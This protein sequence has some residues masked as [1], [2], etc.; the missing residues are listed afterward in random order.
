MSLYSFS[1]S[2]DSLVAINDTA[3][4]RSSVFPETGFTVIDVLSIFVVNSVGYTIF[5]SDVLVVS[6][7]VFSSFRQ[8]LS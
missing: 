6:V 5:S 3:P 8:F 7:S 2:S 4:F 1:L